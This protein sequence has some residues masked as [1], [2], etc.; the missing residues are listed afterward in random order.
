MD[1]RWFVQVLIRNSRNYFLMRFFFPEDGFLGDTVLT[2]RG[3][4]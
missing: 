4:K 2:I 1:H 3:A